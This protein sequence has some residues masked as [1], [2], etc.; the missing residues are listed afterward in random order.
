MLLFSGMWFSCLMDLLVLAGLPIL[1]YVHVADPLLKKPW[2]D[3]VAAS[4]SEPVAP[5]PCNWK[6]RH[7]YH[8]S[9][10]HHCQP[11]QCTKKT[12]FKIFPTLLPPRSLGSILRM[13]LLCSQLR[14]EWKNRQNIITY[15]VSLKLVEHKRISIRK[16]LHAIPMMRRFFCQCKSKCNKKPC[17][18]WR[19]RKECKRKFHSSHQTFIHQGWW[20]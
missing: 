1:G 19:N 4:T 18:C 15:R 9:C 12:P 10:P 11:C 7:S 14:L 13:C 6:Y 8:G 5:A 3:L 2:T 20:V 17:N 16:A